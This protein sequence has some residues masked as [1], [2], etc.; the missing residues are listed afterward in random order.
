MFLP[1]FWCVPIQYT[2][3]FLPDIIL[4]ASHMS[5]VPIELV[6]YTWKGSTR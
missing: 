1:L 5:T 3:G 6:V 2:G 4:C